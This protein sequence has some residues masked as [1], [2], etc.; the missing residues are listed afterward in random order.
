MGF[1]SVRCPR[2]RAICCATRRSKKGRKCRPAA[3][4]CSS[5]GR[6]ACTCP[7]PRR[8]ALTAGFKFWARAGSVYLAPVATVAPTSPSDPSTA[9]ARLRESLMKFL[10]SFSFLCFQLPRPTS[11]PLA[12]RPGSF[13]GSAH[14]IAWSR[15][16]GGFSWQ[17]PSPAHQ[18]EA[19]SAY[20]DVAGI[21]EDGT[22]QS[23]P[24]VAGVFSMVTDARLNAGL[25]PLGYLGPR[26]YQTMRKFPGEA[27]QDISRGNSKTSCPS[28]FGA[29]KDAWDPVTGWGRPQW[30]GLLKHFATDDFL[31]EEN[32][33]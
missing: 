26:L 14:P 3:R 25:P 13:I 28:G 27:F 33:N 29:A 23:S 2:R 20:P 21:S 10:V 7:R 24:L 12:E 1:H 5:N 16:G 32:K 11:L 15:S 6:C 17:F 22:S 18:R 31:Y 30:S 4:S 8:N 9:T 19:V